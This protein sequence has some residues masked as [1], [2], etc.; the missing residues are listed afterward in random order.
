MHLWIID[1]ISNDVGPDERMGEE[2]QER[3]HRTDDRKKIM[4]K[5]RERS[6][7]NQGAVK[8]EAEMP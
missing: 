3:S 4:K 7:I 2:Q 1:K 6:R 5:N 8:W